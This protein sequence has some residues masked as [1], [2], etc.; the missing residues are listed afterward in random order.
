MRLFL[1]ALLA[2]LLAPPALAGDPQGVWLNDAQTLRMR[3]S[4][5]GAAFCGTLVWLRE[6]RNDGYNPDPVKRGQPLLGMR[7]L[8]GMMPTNAPNEWKGSAYGPE[9]GRTY[10]ETMTLKNGSLLTQGCVA[11]GAICHSAAWTKVN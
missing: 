1:I 2:F 3:I 9:D 11:G 7:L 10:V 6:P 5:C 4:P 8:S